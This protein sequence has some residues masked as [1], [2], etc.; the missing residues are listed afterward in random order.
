MPSTGIIQGCAALQIN[1]FPVAGAEILCF[2]DGWNLAVEKAQTVSC[3]HSC[4]TVSVCALG[5]VL[6]TLW[7][8]GLCP[9]HLQTP[10]QWARV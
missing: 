2:G 7:D 8:P 10:A 1:S 3:F 6:F 5:R 4:G 9:S